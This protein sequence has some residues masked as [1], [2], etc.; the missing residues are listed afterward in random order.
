[1]IPWLFKVYTYTEYLKTH[2]QILN[3]DDKNEKKNWKTHHYMDLEYTTSH[4]M[5]EG[6]MKQG[7][8]EFQALTKNTYHYF[9]EC[10]FL[11][12]EIS[13]SISY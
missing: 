3:G 7:M 6:I 5:N 9:D 4:I 12:S 2:M 8:K 1:M 10:L 13:W 11:C